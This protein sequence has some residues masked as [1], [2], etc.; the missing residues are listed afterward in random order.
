MF[1]LFKIECES[2][3]GRYF[4]FWPSV[5]HGRSNGASTQGVCQD[6]IDFRSNDAPMRTRPAG[7]EELHDS[8]S[9]EKHLAGGNIKK[10]PHPWP[11]Q[12]L[13]LEELDDLKELN[14]SQSFKTQ[15]PLTNLQIL[16]NPW[17][18]TGIQDQQ[19]QETLKDSRSNEKAWALQA[20]E[21]VGPL[22][23]WTTSPN[24]TSVSA[25]E[26]KYA[27]TS[28]TIDQ[29]SWYLKGLYQGGPPPKKRW[30]LRPNKGKRTRIKEDLQGQVSLHGGNVGPPVSVERFCEE[31]SM[32]LRS[33]SI[34]VNILIYI[35]DY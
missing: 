7:Q 25:S 21:E 34:F 24:R 16:P 29:V 30:L 4:H 20:H 23:Q 1:D 12:P 8:R 5:T 27:R 2:L 18:L 13:T 31:T 32:K 22:E 35:Y 10:P 11:S 28:T 33:S 14:D 6:L 15:W 9:F 26:N 19:V 17:P 3:T